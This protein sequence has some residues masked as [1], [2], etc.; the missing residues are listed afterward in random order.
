MSSE[1]ESGGLV[2]ALEFAAIV[3][4][5]TALFAAVVG[6]AYVHGNQYLPFSF[7]GLFTVIPL[8]MYLD[9]RFTETQKRGEELAE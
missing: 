9:G 6:Y 2:H 1:Q 7:I 3:V 4:P 8:Y 5:P